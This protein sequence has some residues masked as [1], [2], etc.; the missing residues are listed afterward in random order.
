MVGIARVEV[1]L[2]KTDNT[3]FTRPPL[4]AIIPAGMTPKQRMQVQNDWRM[5]KVQVRAGATL[6]G[7]RPGLRMN[8]NASTVQLWGSSSHP[9]WLFL[10]AAT[11]SSCLAS[12]LASCQPARHTGH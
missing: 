12:L 2:W 10:A 5:G 4:S 1:S 11:A 3:D 8:S 6:H 7:Q 9:V